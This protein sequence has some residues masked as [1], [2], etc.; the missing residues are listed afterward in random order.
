M[1][2]RIVDLPKVKMDK[3][4]LELE[5]I[6]I[7][8]KDLDGII[9]KKSDIEKVIAGLFDQHNLES[10][11]PFSYPLYRV[12]LLLGQKSRTVWI[13]GRTGKHIE[14]RIT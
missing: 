12:K 8:K 11:E 9:I 10:F 13:D 5:A 3:R 7:S 6:T 14:P 2:R 1:F 4:E